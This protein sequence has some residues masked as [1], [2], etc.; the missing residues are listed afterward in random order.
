MC[1][2][3]FMIFD[4]LVPNYGLHV[5]EVFLCLTDGGTTINKSQVGIEG[6]DFWGF[7]ASPQTDVMLGWRISQWNAFEG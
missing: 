2:L 1:M 5:M 3:T 6:T 7:G 4:F